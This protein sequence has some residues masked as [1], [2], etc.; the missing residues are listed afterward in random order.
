MELRAHPN[1]APYLRK[2]GNLPQNYELRLQDVI[3]L[4]EE[5]QGK[6]CPKT[7]GHREAQMLNPERGFNVSMSY[8]CVQLYVRR[9]L[10]NSTFFVY[11]MPFFL[12]TIFASFFRHPCFTMALRDLKFCTMVASLLKKISLLNKLGKS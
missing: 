10:M 2:C 6:L 11:G 8:I 12:I 9:I 5:V 4:I 7:L 1:V 3:K